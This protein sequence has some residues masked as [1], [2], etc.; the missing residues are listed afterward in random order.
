M[1]QVASY[2]YKIKFQHV[3]IYLSDTNYLFLILFFFF[4]N[5]SSHSLENRLFLLLSYT[6]KWPSLRDRP[7]YWSMCRSPSRSWRASTTSVK[8]S[9]VSRHPTSRL[10]PLLLCLIS[11]KP[12]AM[13]WVARRLARPPSALWFSSV[14]NSVSGLRHC[15]TSIQGRPDGQWWRP[16][17]ITFI[18]Q[19]RSLKL[20]KLNCLESRV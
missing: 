7:T 12:S 17:S 4:F 14:S 1:L 5:I 19:V 13:S 15:Q 10:G 20:R 11:H 9:I 16:L 6:I 3:T 18:V 2:N 8:W